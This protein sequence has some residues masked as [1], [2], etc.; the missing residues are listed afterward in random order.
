M[1]PSYKIPLCYSFIVHPPVLPYLGTT[2]VHLCHYL[3]LQIL[4]KLDHEI[5]VVFRLAPHTILPTPGLSPG[6][7]HGQRSLAG[8]S[9]WGCKELDMTERIILSPPPS[10][11]IICWKFIQGFACINSSFLFMA[12]ISWCG[13]TLVCLTT[14]LLKETGSFQFGAIMS[15]DFYEHLCISFCLKTNFYFSEIYAKNTKW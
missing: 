14:H 5:C 8:Y 6:E 15:K 7:F 1:V 13:C 4:Y 2:V 10:L 12:D 3:I 9:P 11:S